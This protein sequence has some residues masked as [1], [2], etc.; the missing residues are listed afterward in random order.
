MWAY[1][2]LG[3]GDEA[4]KD[5]DKLGKLEDSLHSHFTRRTLFCKLNRFKEALSA[6]D[7]EVE[8]SRS[9]EHE[10]RALS[11]RAFILL[12]QQPPQPKDALN[13]IDQLQKVFPDYQHAQYFRGRCQYELKEFDAALQCFDQHLRAAQKRAAHSGL[14]PNES[15]SSTHFFR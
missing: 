13:T 12:L 2:H 15:A 7:R 4:S 6:S 11:G 10:W 9:T 3:R 8:L 5:A 1:F 14:D